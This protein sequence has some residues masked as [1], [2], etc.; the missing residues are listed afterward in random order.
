MKAGVD[1]LHSQQTFL[2]EADALTKKK[3]PSTNQCPRK[4]AIK[5]LSHTIGNLQDQDHVIIL[6]NDTNQTPSECQN[7]NGLNPY[8]IEWLRMKHG[9]DDPFLILHGKHPDTTTTTPHRDI[10]FISHTDLNCKM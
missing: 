2:M 3:A 9:L 5:V 6:T 8:T 4:E 1:A 10:D 7:T